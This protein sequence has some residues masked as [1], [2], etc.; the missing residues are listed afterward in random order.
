MFACSVM[1]S[2]CVNEEFRKEH[3]ESKDNRA[4]LNSIT[5]ETSYHL[6]MLKI[7]QVCEDV[8][9]QKCETALKKFSVNKRINL[10]TL[11][12]IAVTEHKILRS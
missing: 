2:R 3:E 9:G 1:T 4:P 8:I 12:F 7:C 6:Q 11:F 5:A 10:N